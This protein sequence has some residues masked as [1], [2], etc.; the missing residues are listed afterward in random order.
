MPKDY[1]KKHPRILEKDVYDY[2][3]THSNLTRKDAKECFVTYKKMIEELSLSEYI[4]DDTTICLPKL[5]SFYFKVHKGRKKG[6]TYTM[7]L[8]HKVGCKTII[9]EKDEPNSTRLHLKISPLLND[10]VKELREQLERERLNE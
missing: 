5:G 2:I 6:T 8:S 3:A 7:P 1:I 10:R 9:L 4:S